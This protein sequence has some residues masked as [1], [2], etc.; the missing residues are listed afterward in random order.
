M[1]FCLLECD[2]HMHCVHIVYIV[3]MYMFYMQAQV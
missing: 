1:Y 3:Y 2:T